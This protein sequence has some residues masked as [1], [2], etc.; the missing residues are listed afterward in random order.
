MSNKEQNMKSVEDGEKSGFSQAEGRGHSNSHA[1][2]NNLPPKKRFENQ[3]F[4]SW[5]E[6]SE[7]NEESKTEESKTVSILAV[8][9]SHTSCPDNTLAYYYNYNSSSK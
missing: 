5:Q 1:S 3:N 6:G 4:N 7:L 8:V 2:Q 9:I